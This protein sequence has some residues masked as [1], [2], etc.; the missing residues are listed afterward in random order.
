MLLLAHLMTLDQDLR[1]RTVRLVRAVKTEDEVEKAEASLLK[2]IEESRVRAVAKVVHGDD[3]IPLLH[4]VAEEAAVV[5]I[6]FEPP[7]EGEEAPWRENLTQWMP[8]GRYVLLV[9]SAGGHS[10]T[11]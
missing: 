5:M 3:V 4:G 1:N 11:S 2:L 8:E 9:S 10:L 6:G 7:P